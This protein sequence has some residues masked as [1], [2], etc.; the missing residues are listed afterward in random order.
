MKALGN[1]PSAVSRVLHS[2]LC[3]LLFFALHLSLFTAVEAAVFVCTVQYPYDCVPQ[4]ATDP[5]RYA[6]PG[7]AEW[8]EVFSCVGE[9]REVVLSAKELPRDYMLTRFVY[10]PSQSPYTGLADDFSVS[11]EKVK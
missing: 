2:A 6:K 7:I 1:Q 4:T 3:A 9:V 8:K 10:M 11:C 5:A